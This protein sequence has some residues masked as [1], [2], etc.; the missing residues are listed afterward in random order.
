VSLEGN[1]VIVRNLEFFSEIT[2]NSDD[3]TNLR[4]NIQNLINENQV[5]SNNISS[6]LSSQI[7]DLVKNIDTV[8]N[9]SLEQYVVEPTYSSDSI[10][11]SLK[12][13]VG[14]YKF[15]TTSF[16]NVTI[17]SNQISL[18]SLTLFTPPTPSSITWFTWDGTKITGLTSSG[19]NQ[20]N[21]VIPEIAT[22][23]YQNAFKDKTNIISVDTSFSKITSIGNYAFSGCTNLSSIK[24]NSSIKS[25]G[26]YAFN[27]CTKLSSIILPDSLNMIDSYCFNDCRSLSTISNWPDSWTSGN[28]VFYN[29]ENLKSVTLSSGFTNVPT[30]MFFNCAKLSS[31]T[32]LGRLTSI[33]NYAFYNCSSLESLHYQIV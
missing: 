10:N 20:T 32:F 14:R 11:I 2:F 28:A 26:A 15:K 25:F 16:T 12:S 27:N 9:G 4:T 30:N 5:N 23:I 6:Y 18:N 29:C 21:L 31:I 22:Q 8:N 3:L 17:S 13:D 33:S 1:K 19:Q 24:F 7:Y